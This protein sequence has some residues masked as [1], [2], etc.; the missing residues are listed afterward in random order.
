MANRGQVEYGEPHIIPNV[1]IDAPGTSLKIEAGEV[2]G[3][4]NYTVPTFYGVCLHT[5]ANGD[6]GALGVNEHYRVRKETGTGAAI[7][8]FDYITFVAGPAADNY[9]MAS[10][11]GTGDDIHG[12]A[13]EAADDDAEDILIHGPLFPF[14]Y[15]TV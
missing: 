14:P 12:I 2:A 10:K 6:T 5:Y 1:P 11:A 8:Q 13:L 3:V 9:Y 7:A 15:Q 4:P